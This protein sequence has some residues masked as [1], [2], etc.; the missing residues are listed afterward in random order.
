LEFANRN[1]GNNVSSSDR[2]R[3]AI[4]RN[5]AKVA[6][7]TAKASSASNLGSAT[8]SNL[9]D[10]LA[11]LKEKRAQLQNT[12]GSKSSVLPNSGQSKLSSFSSNTR[13]DPTVASKIEILKARR[14]N[15][16]TP[17]PVRTATSAVKSS[18]GIGEKLAEKNFSF[19][20]KI[21]STAIRAL[22]AKTLRV[23]IWA[24]NILFLGVAI[25]GDR[26]VVDYISRHG[27]LVEKENHISFLER[28]NEEIKLQIYRLAN[29]SNYQKQVIRDYLGYIAKD[30]YLVIFAE[31]RS[32]AP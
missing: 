12:R 16:A 14:Q 26:G 30:E 25:F 24:L 5:R 8:S 11:K 28:E 6:Q 1:T 3:K 21:F 31:N 13:S 19:F 29:E 27:K 7:K 9:S 32:E 15:I 20:D 22:L 18:P 2:L 17:K 10:R 4:E 23:G